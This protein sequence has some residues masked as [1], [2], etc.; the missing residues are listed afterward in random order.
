MIV[1]VDILRLTYSVS[2]IARV[3]SV[4]FNG[5]CFVPIEINMF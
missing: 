4:N 2:Y 5:V 1:Q 3:E